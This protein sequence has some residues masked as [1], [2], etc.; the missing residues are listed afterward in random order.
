MS[1]ER[2]KTNLNLENEN[3]TKRGSDGGVKWRNTFICDDK[4]AQY[5][6]QVC[7]MYYVHDITAPH[8]ISI[9]DMVDNRRY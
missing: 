2:G 9:N 1:M 8:S 5:A 7:L 4:Y 3:I 6:Q